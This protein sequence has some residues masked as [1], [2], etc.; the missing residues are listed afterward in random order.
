M[1]CCK[2][3]KRIHVVQFSL[4]PSRLQHAKSCGELA[5]IFMLH[6]RILHS[7]PTCFAFCSSLLR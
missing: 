2:S 7:L 6:A 3:Y 5:F 4:V 1:K